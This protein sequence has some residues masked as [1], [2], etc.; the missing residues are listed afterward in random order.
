MR[1]AREEL[2]A[3][4]GIYVDS[5]A[6]PNGGREPRV[7]LIPFDSIGLGTARRYLVKNLVP[8]VGIT[9]VWGPP[10]SGKSFWTFDLVMHVALNWPYRGRRVHHG[11][12]VYCA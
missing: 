4:A 8:R 5:A 3:Q 1:S 9:V 2:L 11:A 6:K 10:K 7:C 12:V